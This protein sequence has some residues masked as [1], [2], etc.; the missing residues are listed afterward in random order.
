MPAGGEH[1]AGQTSVRPNV[2]W[3]I[4]DWEVTC[5]SFV[6]APLRPGK[7]WTPW[8]LKWLHVHWVIIVDDAVLIIILMH[9][10]TG[11]DNNFAGL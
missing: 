1:S 5:L 11:A 7:E 2:P 4:A 3:A 6:S 9:Y 10:N 8:L